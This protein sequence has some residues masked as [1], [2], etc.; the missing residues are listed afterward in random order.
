MKRW[1]GF[2]LLAL[3]LLGGFWFLQHRATASAEDD[4]R[5]V[6]IQRRTLKRYIEAVG[7][8]N[9]AFTL[10]VKSKASGE[11]VSM[12]YE[13]GDTVKEGDLLVELLPVDELRNLRKQ[14]A[15]LQAATAQLESART[16]LKRAER[17]L[18]LEKRRSASRL[19]EAR[20]SDRIAQKNL[21]R[22]LHLKKRDLASTQAVENASQT[23]QSS[24]SALEIAKTGVEA[25]ELLEFDVSDQ[26]HTIQLQEAR[27][28]QEKIELEV[29]TLRLAETKIRAGMDGVVLERKVERGQ[30]I[31]SGI[32]NVS[33]GTTLLVLAD[34]RRLFLEAQVDEA[35]IGVVKVHGEVELRAEAFPEQLFTGRI[36]R[37]APRGE[38]IQSVTVFKVRIELGEDA[39]LHLRPGMNATARILAETQK[40][41]LAVPLAAI[42]RKKAE[43]GV[44]RK[45][46][47][48][49]FIPIQAGLQEDLLVE[50]Q[51]DVKEGDLVLL[52]PEQASETED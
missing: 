8:V 50:I 34:V 51:G 9:P 6:P 35:D 4:T 25:L 36:D 19:G 15:R 39:R 45:G 37:V 31:A 23:A 26:M 18:V 11:V 27:V 47:E 33:G 42:H 24:K 49:K 21:T 29:A 38:E 13:E 10:E 5:Y 1:I 32:S 48:E 14:K 16:Q 43:R 44:Y 12:P 3:F 17:N 2:G 7:V 40:D 22:Q 52:D 28:E 46:K 20:S 30:I 41:V